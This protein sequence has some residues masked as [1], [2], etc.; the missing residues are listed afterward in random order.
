M[1]RFSAAF[2]MKEQMVLMGEQGYKVQDGIVIMLI[3]RQ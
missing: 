1:M 2:K 3:T